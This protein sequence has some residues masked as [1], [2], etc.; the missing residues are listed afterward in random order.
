[1]LVTCTV[2]NR[3]ASDYHRIRL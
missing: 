1:M 2:T 3:Q